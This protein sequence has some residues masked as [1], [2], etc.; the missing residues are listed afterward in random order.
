LFKEEHMSESENQPADEPPIPDPQPLVPAPSPADG[1]QSGSD[2]KRGDELRFSNK[3]EILA[4][5]DRMPGMIAMGLLPPARAN[6]MRSIFHTMLSHLGESSPSAGA[7]AADEDVV[8]ILR[9]QPELLKIFL[10]FLTREQVDLVI[11][12]APR[13]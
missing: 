7:V 3:H 10:P 1:H 13:E 5:L 11:R 12:E 8:K 4:K 6:S 9:L 2:A